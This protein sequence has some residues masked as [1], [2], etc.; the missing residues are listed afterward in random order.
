MGRN[1]RNII[2]KISGVIITSI[3]ILNPLYLNLAGNVSANP[4]PYIDYQGRLS[5]SNGNLLTGNYYITFCIYSVSSPATNCT[6]PASPSGS[7]GT[8]ST[9]GSAVWGE[10]RY[11]SSTNS[12]SNEVLNGVFNTHLGSQSALPTNLFSANSDLYLGLNVY[13]G[14]S[15]DGQMTPLEEIV[16]SGYSIASGGLTSGT[17][18]YSASQTPAAN[19]I[20]ILDSS[21]N[22][23]LPANLNVTAGNTTFGGGNVTITGSNSLYFYNNSFG[24]M[25][26]GTNLYI[27]K[28]IPTNG[29]IY[30]DNST[31]YFQNGDLTLNGL[32]DYING[33]ISDSGGYITMQKVINPTAAPTLGEVAVSGLPATTYYVKY[34][35][36][37]AAGETGASPEASYTTGA[38]Y[39]L[40]ATVSF[41]G[42]ITSANI[43]VS[44]TSGSETLQTNPI[45]VSGGT[46]TEPSTNITTNG[47]SAPTLSSAGGYITLDNTAGNGTSKIYTNRYGVNFETTSNY[48]YFVGSGTNGDTFNIDAAS[49][50]VSL[51]TNSYTFNINS[52]GVVINSPSGYSGDLLDVKN[53]GTTEIAVAN[54]GNVTVTNNLTVDGGITS[55][56]SALIGG[57]LTAN[58]GT[59]TLGTTNTGN[60]A[61]TGSFS[62]SGRGSNYCTDTSSFTYTFSS[63]NPA[64]TVM[65][66][67]FTMSTTNPILVLFNSYY[68]VASNQYS[69][70]IFYF[71]VD[72]TGSSPS[73][74]ALFA[75]SSSANQVL[76]PSLSFIYTGVGSG[77]HAV[78]LEMQG[79]DVTSG[80][81]TIYPN[82][83]LQ[84]IE[85]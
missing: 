6:P 82:I 75:N 22:L 5:D 37:N 20:P 46:W 73:T 11:F 53:N 27:A 23:T 72:G 47:A 65:T 74:K 15:W 44:T 18:T 39:G 41:S 13:N 25:S 51:N 4:L 2:R 64:V 77:A 58:G 17:S 67:S 3:L 85:L 9:L 84:V 48:W 56:G 24:I 21:G 31:D 76:T 70:D 43:Y 16:S 33:D 55:S 61:T 36:V 69:D 59:T 54:G 52:G 35:W 71:T 57:N 26:N 80:T 40:T 66:C 62:F 81:S 34:T 50:N 29:S 32:N 14:S 49:N 63:T 78:Y 28:Y 38:G 79:S 83:T 19:Q 10:Y 68:A 30:L 45:T 1:L 12:P 60:L 42:T 8:I 7:G